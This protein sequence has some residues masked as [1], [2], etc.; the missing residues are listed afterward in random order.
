MSA[1]SRPEPAVRLV[2]VCKSFDRTPVLDGFDLDVELG[3]TTVLLGPSGC[4][5]SVTLKLI[6]GLLRPDAGEVHLFGR[7]IDRLPE[8]ELLKERLKIGFLFQMGALF[9]SMNVEE[10]IAFPLREHTRMSPEERHARVHECLE[11]VDLVGFESRLPG[12]LSGGQRK[13]VA[14]AR[15][16]VLR[17]QLMLYDEP[18]TGLDPV[19]SDGINQLINKLQR[20]LGVTGLVVTHDLAAARKV[21]DRVAM[22]YGGRLIA[23]GTYSDLEHSTHPYVRHF[24]EGLYEPE[25]ESGTPAGTARVRTQERRS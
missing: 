21:A 5:K 19:R 1:E 14:L 18:T 10:N 25:Q 3:K 11:V 20:T 13:R 15:A 12:Q 17:P 8:R 9:D 24:V 2:G 4:G 16:F 23:S 7:R 6:A 22:L